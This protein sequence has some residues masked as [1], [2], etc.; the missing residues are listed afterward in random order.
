MH[1]SS[2]AQLKSG[3]VAN[4]EVR[5]SETTREH[6]SGDPH[7]VPVPD[8][9]P[10]MPRRDVAA[11]EGA[12]ISPP[13]E[14]NG[15]WIDLAQSLP[16]QAVRTQAITEQHAKPVVTWFARVL[17][18]H[19][20]EAAWRMGE[21]GEELV[22]KELSH[23]PEGWHTLHSIQVGD[24][25][26]D[27]DHLVIGRGGIFSLNTKHHKNASIWV[28]GNTFM[29]NGQKQPYLRNSRHEAQRAA[30]ILSV[31]SGIPVTVKGVVVVVNAGSFTI[32][33]RPVDVEVL[34][35]RQLRNWLQQ[36]RWVLDQATV[37]RIFDA[38]R[39]SS[40]WS[41]KR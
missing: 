37:E 30:R 38:A 25:G 1:S 13:R 6:D 29:V 3:C 32:R 24:R 16:A 41:G 2:N 14:V 10:S 28:A 36:Q 8:K 33:E 35:R 39:R 7:I 4:P 20:D 5:L 26:S 15:S 17:G 31:A 27:I 23:L 21:K 19:T 22:A 34:Y 11:K 40:T 9:T 12:C 18:V